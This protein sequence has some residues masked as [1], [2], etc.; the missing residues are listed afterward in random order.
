MR[1]S[2]SFNRPRLAL[3]LICCY[4]NTCFC[5]Q[6]RFSSFP[7]EPRGTS[8]GAAVSRRSAPAVRHRGELL[9]EEWEE[10]KAA[11]SVAA[12]DPSRGGCWEI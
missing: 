10:L 8:G 9:P 3:M 12:F 2:A 7:K 1:L 11:G 5:L 4:A 6:S